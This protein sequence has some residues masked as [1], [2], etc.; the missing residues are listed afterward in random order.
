MEFNPWGRSFIDWDRGPPTEPPARDQTY[1]VSFYLDDRVIYV[2]EYA[3]NAEDEAGL[4]YI[5]GPEH[6]DYRH[7][8][9]TIM[10]ASSS[11]RWN[12]EGRWQYAT[13]EWAALMP[14][15]ARVQPPATGNGG[16]R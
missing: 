13:A 9:G 2:L 10:G 7:N 4:I 15:P 3:P 12:P 14:I 6:P 8:I 16:L 1:T 5:P 11:D